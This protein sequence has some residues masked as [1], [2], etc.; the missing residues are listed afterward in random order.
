MWHTLL[1]GVPAYL[2][3]TALPEDEEWIRYIEAWE[4]VYIQGYG[5]AC[6]VFLECGKQVYIGLS[7]RSLLHRVAAYHALDL[8][9][10]RRH[11]YD[12]T[13]QKQTP[14]LPIS[15]R[16]LILFAYKARSYEDRRWRNDGA[17]GYVAMERIE[18]IDPVD[19]APHPLTRVTL[20]SGV[21]LE[22]RMRCGN[23]RTRMHS[24]DYFKYYLAKHG[25]Q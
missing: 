6:R 5:N 8:Q 12:A 1:P 24:A 9:R 22:A 15:S 13:R 3:R 18:R 10:L 23:F 19:H 2:G 17:M 4:P 7:T 20:T 25:I 14:P 16:G 11:F 21:V